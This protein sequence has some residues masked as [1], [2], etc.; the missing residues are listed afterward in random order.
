MEEDMTSV[1]YF[2][3]SEGK[4][5]KKHRLGAL[6]LPEFTADMGEERIRFCPVPEFYLGK[7]AWDAEKLAG[8]LQRK[9][10]AGAADGYYVQ[11]E[12]CA[13]LGLEERLPPLF[14]LK[15]VLRQNGCWENVIYIGRGDADGRLEEQGEEEFLFV[16]LTEYLPRVNHFTV[17]TKNPQ[18]Y[19]GFLDYIYEEYGIPAVCA[20]QLEK[21]EESGKRTTVLDNCRRY[22]PRLERLPDS[23]SYIDLWSQKEKRRRIETGRRD[24]SYFAAVKFLD[25]MGKNGYNTIVN[26]T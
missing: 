8:L 23:A 14:L 12:L 22:R 19:V 20:D 11:P 21:R 18:V 25:T 15:K 1:F 7:R 26:Q 24:I 9:L 6:R 4:S 13:L 10:E 3:L 17:V 16:L 5:A 2:Y